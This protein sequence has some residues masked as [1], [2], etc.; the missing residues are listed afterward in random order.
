MKTLIFALILVLSQTSRATVDWKNPEVICPEAA[1]AQGLPCLDLTGVT[2]PNTDFPADLDHDSIE[3]WKTQWSA[4]LKVCR[5][6]EVLRREAQTPGSFTPLQVQI[7]FMLAGAGQNAQG[8]L[9]K[10]Y[11]AAALVDMPVHTLVGALTQESLLSDL[12]IS[13]D[14]GNYSCGIGQLNVSEWCQGMQGLSVQERTQLGW[15]AIA[16]ESVAPA[17]LAPFYTIAAARLQGRPAY[18]IDARDF[19]GIKFEQVSG[20]FPSAA[21]ATQRARFQAL[22]SFIQNC[23]NPLLGI[24]FKAKNLR[25]MFDTYVP[26]KMRQAERYSEG[27]TFSRACGRTYVSKFYPLHTGWLLTLAMYN[28]GPSMVKLLEHYHQTSA[29]KLPTLLPTDLIEALYWGGEYRQSTGRIHYRGANQRDYSQTWTKSCVVQRH[30]AR[31]IQHVSRPGHTLATSLE[32]TPCAQ[33][34]TARRMNA[35]G[36]K[37]R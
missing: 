13:P 31:V 33:G 19:L 4:D 11:E 14:G 16:C 32:E 5:A 10:L 7:S 9:A 17:M 30:V 29:E 15:P 3:R 23:Q 6:K 22:T 2:N 34:I 20:S 18:Q 35:S 1:F 25:K 12:G 24:P 36:I 26:S 21:E 28:A 8:K 27:E 37:T